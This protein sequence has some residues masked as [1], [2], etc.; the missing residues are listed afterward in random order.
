VE[1]DYRNDPNSGRLGI[2]E[3]E[4]L[5]FSPARIYWISDFISGSIRGNHAHKTLRQ[6]MFVIAGSINI[7][8][9]EGNNKIFHKIE[10]SGYVLYIEPGIWREF[11]TDEPG[12]IVCVLCDQ[13]FN[14]SDYIRNFHEYISW[15]KSKNEC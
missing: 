10:P 11:W 1:I 4:N 3:F 13:P 6:A 12:S 9:Y 2:I 8:L 14:E 15:F 5:K 7:N